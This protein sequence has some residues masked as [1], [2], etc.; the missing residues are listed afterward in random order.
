MQDIPM[1]TTEFG[2]ASLF[3]QEIPY[4]KRAH[5]KLQATQDPAQLLQECVSFCRVCGAEWID[6]AG[7]PWLECYPKITT[8][9]E[10]CCRKDALPQTDVCLFPVTEKTLQ[11]WLD[12]YNEKMQ[13]I[14]NAAY[15]DSRAGKQM[16]QKGDGYFVH[17]NGNLLGIGKASVDFI[18]AVIA[19]EPGAG[20][21]VVRALASVLSEDVIRL[22]VADTNARAVRLYERLGFVAVKQLSTWYRVL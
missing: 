3:L 15:M 1:F 10:M 12:I 20:E 8:L 16:L 13:N 17:R 18:D 21:T 6:A 19:T 4:R 5:I 14:P 7:H 2:V 22:W 11:Q 9:V